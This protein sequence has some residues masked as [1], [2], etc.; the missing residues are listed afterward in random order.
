MSLKTKD[1]CGELWNE[2][3]MSM[4]KGT[5][6]LLAGMLLKIQMVSQQVAGRKEGGTGGRRPK[7]A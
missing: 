5:Y 1:H 4:K 3:G 2:A 6:R 7:S